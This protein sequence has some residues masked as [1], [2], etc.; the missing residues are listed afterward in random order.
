MVA[1]QSASAIEPRSV[2]SASET[3]LPAA[4]S[5]STAPASIRQTCLSCGSR[6]RTDSTTASWAADSTTQATAAESLRI[7]STCSADEVSYTGTVTAPALQIAKS[8]SVHSYRV[9]DIR[10]TRSPGCT[11][12][13]I[14]PLAADLTSARKAAEVTSCQVPATFLASTAVS[15]YW[16]AFRRIRSVR[17]P[18]AGTSYRAGRL[19]SRKTAA[20]RRRR[21][22]CRLRS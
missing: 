16:V 17:L 2:T 14:R 5:V 6:S 21:R 20:P 10:A 7:H 1:G 3:S 12:E 8:S 15:G 9:R 18:S 13:A 22:R 11:P 19:N 4:A